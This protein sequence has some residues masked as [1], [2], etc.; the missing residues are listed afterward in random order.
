MFRDLERAQTVFTGLAAHRLID[1]NLSFDRQTVSGNGLLV[2]GSYF[3]VLGVRPALG[4]LLGPDDDR[5]PGESPV[6]VL[7]YEYW[8]TRLGASPAILGKT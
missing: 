6:V 5:A 4:R 8:Q 1:T 7:D 2:S 3:P